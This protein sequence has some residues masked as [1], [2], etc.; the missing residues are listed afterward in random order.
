MR[1]DCIDEVS[2]HELREVF[3]SMKLVIQTT[4]GI[5]PYRR[6]TSLNCR[7]GC[8]DICVIPVKRVSAKVGNGIPERSI[9]LTEQHDSASLEPK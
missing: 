2:A 5:L 8:V 3:H 7:L 9:V 6:G 1:L 4:R